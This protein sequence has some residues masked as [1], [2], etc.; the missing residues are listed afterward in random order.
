MCDIF[1]ATSSAGQCS[2]STLDSAGGPGCPE[3][4][5]PKIVLPCNL[6]ILTETEATVPSD[7]S[8]LIIAGAEKVKLTAQGAQ[9]S[10][11]WTLAGKS[12]LSSK[13]GNE[14]T[15]TAHTEAETVSIEATDSQGCIAKVQFTVKI[16]KSLIHF[17]PMNSWRGEYGFDWLRIGGPAEV[18]L[19]GTQ[20]IAY[21]NELTGGFGFANAAAAYAAL[22]T[23]YEPS[24]VVAELPSSPENLN[25]YFVPFLNFFPKNTLEPHVPAGSPPP[26]SEAKLKILVE[27][28]DNAPDA[29]E[30][31]CTDTTALHLSTNSLSDKGVCAKKTSADTLT[32]TCNTAISSPQYINVFSRFLGKRTLVGKLN[33]CPNNNIA[34][35]KIKFLFVKVKTNIT[36]SSANRGTFNTTETRNLL[37]ALHQGLWTADIEYGPDL[38]LRNDPNF[39]LATPTH[40][41]RNALGF[42]IPGMNWLNHPLNPNSITRY[43]KNTYLAIPSN[44]KYSTGYFLIFSVGESATTIGTTM[45]WFGFVEDFSLRNAVLYNGRPATTLNHECLHG[46]GLHHTFS[47]SPDHASQKYLYPNGPFTDNVMSYNHGSQFTTW[48]WQWQLL[49]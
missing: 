30:V 23:D 47:D 31:E 35:K 8:R 17:R 26:L 4:E 41:T 6:S 19:D 13:T 27:V 45:Q 48:K 7:R 12:L 28:K 34:S 38:D 49:S 16:S 46:L 36:G 11:N 44:N 10:V 14:V 32:V 2:D 3:P 42:V 29:I 24:G 39:Q 33:I 15:L 21:K 43:L 20:E 18:K 5:E 25:E 22:K 9:G 40:P 1:G 37:N